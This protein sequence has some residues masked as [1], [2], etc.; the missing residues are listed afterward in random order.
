MHASRSARGPVRAI[1]TARL[2]S[3]IGGHAAFVALTLDVYSHSWSEVA[4]A[5][6]ADS[7]ILAPAHHAEET[8]DVLD[9]G[10]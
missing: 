5:L 2:I 6:T 10:S 7:H 3:L 9:R 1:A 4:R 8:D